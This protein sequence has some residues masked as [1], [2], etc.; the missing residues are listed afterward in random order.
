MYS[1]DASGVKRMMVLSACPCANSC[2]G[3][4]TN[5]GGDSFQPQTPVL[6][7]QVS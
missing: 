4:D 6:K 1:L 3:M 5:R 7:F 2:Q